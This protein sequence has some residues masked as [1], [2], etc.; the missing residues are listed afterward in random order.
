MPKGRV[1]ETA[2]ADCTFDVATTGDTHF[3]ENAAAVG[4]LF[5]RA[6]RVQ[7]GAMSF[8]CDGTSG[9]TGWT[10]RVTQLVGAVVGSDMTLGLETLQNGQPRVELLHCGPVNET[11]EAA[12][13]NHTVG[14]AFQGA[15]VVE[16]LRLD[17]GEELEVHGR[18]K[19]RDSR[20]DRQPC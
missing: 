19:C 16:R 20:E 4:I 7:S 11:R 1:P 3:A 8:S 2:L 18:A 9:E 5:D 15:K 6:R 13:V 17:S 14:I 10:C 12:C